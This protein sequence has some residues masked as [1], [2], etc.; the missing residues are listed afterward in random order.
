MADA[1]FHGLVATQFL[2]AFNDNIF[3]QIVLLLFQAVPLAVWESSAAGTRDCQSLG[4]FVFAIPF[5][6][7]SGYAGFLA[8]RFGK[9]R[10]IVLS[11]VAE[12]VVMLLG[13]GMLWWYVTHGWSLVTL[14]GI[15]SV[16]FL[17]GMQSAFFGP[18][19]YGVLP[20]LFRDKD[21]P[22]ANGVVLMTTFVAIILGVGA[23]G[24]LMESWATQLWMVGCICVL[25]AV[26][27]T[28]TSFTLRRPPPANPS[29]HF[30]GMDTLALPADMR[31]T[32]ANDR[33][34]RQA[35]I[36]SSIFWLCAAVVHPA[37]IAYGK[38]QLVLG[39]TYTSLLTAGI[40][41]GIAV[42]SVVTGYISGGAIAWRSLRVGL[43][44][45]AGCLLFLA[46]WGGEPD[47]T[48]DVKVAAV[49]LVLLGGFTGMFAVPVQV[50][51]QQRPPDALKGRMFA[52]VNLLNWV[53]I[54]ASAGIYQALV[55]A[56]RVFGWSTSTCFAII[57]VPLVVLAIGYRPQRL[58]AMTRE[59]SQ[60]AAE[61][62]DGSR[63][64]RADDD[65]NPYQPPGA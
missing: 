63:P 6:L 3:K 19:K 13:T 38:E 30:Q 1:S 5:V 56:Q 24:A 52:T 40:S 23:A 25:I 54:V 18:S 47:R 53:G 15:A 29:L 51:L 17:M 27:G 59:L 16:L 36:V 41:I 2:G 21:L 48:V 20:E 62:D 57:A 42:G 14:V 11:K 32:L 49:L 34:L 50:F 35:V 10:V 8:D 26:V 55:I 65:S 60:S 31:A 12:I 46:L 7:F 22:A 4:L 44:G 45:M 33:A 28:A 58:L 64:Y 39:D 9:R 43:A 37:V 61:T